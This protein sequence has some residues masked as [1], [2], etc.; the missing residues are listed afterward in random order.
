[1]AIIITKVGMDIMRMN[2]YIDAGKLLLKPSAI[3]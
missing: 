3:L 1:M 2:V